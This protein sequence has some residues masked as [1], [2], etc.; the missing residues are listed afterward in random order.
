MVH[1]YVLFPFTA[2]N[3]STILPKM[4]NEKTTTQPPSQPAM[5]DEEARKSKRNQSI[6]VL[7]FSVLVMALVAVFF[8]VDLAKIKTFITSAGPWGILI[9]ILFYALMGLTLIPSEPFTLF[10]GALFGPFYAT[11][12]ATVGNVLSACVEYFL[13]SHLGSATNFIEKKDKLP[14]GL[15]KLKV[16]SPLFLIGARMIPGYGSKVVSVIAG[17]YRVPV[18]RY[19]WTASIPIFLGSAIFAFGGFG[20][21]KLIHLP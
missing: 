15:G 13:G 12:I 17:I 2:Q 9:S 3:F 1:F 8:T 14:F 7:I 21:G 6:S 16:E 19:V 20:I 11:L 4:D 18:Y 5:E 10:I